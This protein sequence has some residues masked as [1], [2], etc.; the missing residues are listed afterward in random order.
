M[1]VDVSNELNVFSN[2]DRDKYTH[3]YICVCIF[4]YTHTCYMLKCRFNYIFRH[5]HFLVNLIP[6]YCVCIIACSF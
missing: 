6:Y 3:K 1:L 4:M 2:S 5:E